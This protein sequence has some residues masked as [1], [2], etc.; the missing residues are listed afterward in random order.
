MKVGQFINNLGGLGVTDNVGINANSN[1]NETFLDFLY[2]LLFYYNRDESCKPILESGNTQK[3]E[4]GQGSAI[5][6]SFQGKD[7]SGCY[8]KLYSYVV[9]L[10]KKYKNVG[11]EVVG[12]SVLV[13][14]T[15]EQQ[16]TNTQNKQETKTPT[17]INWAQFPCVTGATGVVEGKENNQ[18]VYSGSGYVWYGNGSRKE[19]KTNKISFYECSSDGKILAKSTPPKLIPPSNVPKPETDT[20]SLNF[21]D[22]TIGELTK[23]LDANKM[24]QD[25]ISSVS[26]VQKESV[27]NKKLVEQLNRIKQLL[28]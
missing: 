3:T 16:I 21:L 1:L 22:S 5:F 13:F 6:I 17:Q 12:N 26:G 23:G 8:T 9:S 20:Q 24:A 18:V 25:F 19:I 28:K 15:P 2:E 4:Y 10:Q 27:K 14:L 11:Y 7:N